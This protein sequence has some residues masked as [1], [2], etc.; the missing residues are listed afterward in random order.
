MTT[1]EFIPYHNIHIVFKLD[2]GAELSG[3]IWDRMDWDL[4]G[5]SES[6]YRFVPTGNMIAWKKAEREK[7][8]EAQSRLET[9][10][11]LHNIVWAELLN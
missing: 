4:T 7:D 5:K 11:D 10:I 8:K 9:D 6:V 2:N 1:A 3:A